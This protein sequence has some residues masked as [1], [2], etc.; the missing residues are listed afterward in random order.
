M[1]GP[2]VLLF[3]GTLL[4]W[5]L[6]TRQASEE[7]LSPFRDRTLA[8]LDEMRACGDALSAG[9]Y[10]SSSAA[11]EV[12][13]ALRAL[14]PERDAPWR[15]DD[16]DLFRR[17]LGDGERSA[18]FR[19]RSH[20]PGRVELLLGEHEVAFFYLRVGDDVAR[21]ELPRWATAPAQIA[22]LHATLVD[23]C[24]RC[25]G[26]PR[27]LQEAHEQAVISTGDRVQFERLLDEEAARH[28]LRRAVNGKDTS[29]RRR[30]L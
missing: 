22:R 7:A 25:E 21:V 5:D 14:V 23:Q 20:R 27:A 1:E 12:T 2:V 26:Y 10:V 11:S 17:L 18:L 8:A 6:H 29:K 30:S 19:S 16:G 13:N 4:P 3:D 9:A 28:G 24:R 15:F